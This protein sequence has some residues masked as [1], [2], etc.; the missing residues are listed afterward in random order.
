[1]YYNTLKGAPTFRR[2]FHIA[3]KKS[4]GTSSDFYEDV[5]SLA[6]PLRA[7]HETGN[8]KL[9]PPL[10][11]I[12]LQIVPNV[13]PVASRAESVGLLLHAVLPAGLSLA[14]PA[15]STLV[16]LCSDEHWRAVRAL[17]DASLLVNSHDRKQSLE[18]ANAIPNVNKR[19]TTI[20]QIEDGEKMSPRPF[21][22]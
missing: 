9:I 2:E 22:W 20:Q 8:P 6:W 4:A 14:K 11:H 17:V 12:A 16:N 3:V 7:L 18:I 13:S 19:T 5:M 15:I 21:F 10:L 1:V